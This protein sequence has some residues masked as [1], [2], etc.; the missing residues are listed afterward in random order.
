[1]ST[2]VNAPLE[3]HTESD[4]KYE[5]W[6]L[7]PDPSLLNLDEE[8]F[9]F[10]GNWAGIRDEEELKKHIIEVQA[11]AYAVRGHSNAVVCL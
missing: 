5:K 9:S 6:P 1:M 3:K 8:E 2:A 4:L 11:K 10:F 7:N